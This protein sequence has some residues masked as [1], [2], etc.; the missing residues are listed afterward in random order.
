MRGFGRVGVLALLAA[1]AIG[2]AGAVWWQLS[3][4]TIVAIPAL[5]APIVEAVAQTTALVTQEVAERKA[6]NDRVAAAVTEAQ[7]LLQGDVCDPKHSAA[8]ESLLEKLEF[9]AMI[10]TPQAAPQTNALAAL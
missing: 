10:E 3:H 5:P 8:L 7:R 6:S 9:A 1:A 4:P 2:L